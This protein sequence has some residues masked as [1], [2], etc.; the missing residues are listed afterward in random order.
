MAEKYLKNDKKENSN[1]C[2]FSMNLL[3]FENS[4][5]FFQF[6]DINFFS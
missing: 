2:S 4:C 1:N 3:I 5:E 6:F